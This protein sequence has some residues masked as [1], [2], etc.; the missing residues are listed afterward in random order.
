MHSLPTLPRLSWLER[1]L[2]AFAASLLAIGIAGLAG[3]WLHIDSLVMPWSSE[4]IQVGEALSFLVLG[5]ALITRELG[6]RSAGWLGLAPFALAAVTLLESAFNRDWH[7]S[8]LFLIDRLA[9][10]GAHPGRSA[11]ITGACMGF[12]ALIVI[13]HSAP[14]AARARMFTGAV[15]GS[16]LAAVGFST[17]LGYSADLPAIYDWGSSLAIAP[18]SALGLFLL[19]LSLLLLAWRESLKEKNEP[20]VW[21]PLPAVIACLTLTM[22]LWVGL[23]DREHAYLNAK[24]LQA[25]GTLAGAIDSRIEIEK[26]AF[27]RVART[28]S[29]APE[30]DAVIWDAD[31]RKQLTDSAPFGCKSIAY[32]DDTLRTRWIYPKGGNEWAINFNHLSVGAR[33]DAIKEALDHLSKS[34]PTISGTTAVDG[35]VERGFVIYAP[36]IRHARAAGFVAGEY[37]YAIFFRKIADDF[38]GSYHVTIAIGADPYYDAGPA[39]AA[40]NTGY[41]IDKTYTIE[42]FEGR[43]LQ[44]T[45]T[46]S[47]DLVASGSGSLPEFALAAGISVTA[48]LGLS[49][50][51]FRRARAGQLS[52]EV[53]NK[54]LLSEN[55]ERRR[56]ETRLKIS[57]E[58]L[59]LALDSTEIGIFEWNVPTGHVYYS[60]GLWAMLGYEHDRMPGTL[61]AWQSL[62]H[63]DDLGVYRPKIESQLNGAATFIDLEYRIR[64]RTGDW[65]WIYGRSKSISTDFQGRPARIIGTVQDITARVE[66]EHQLRRAKTEADATSRAKSEFLASMSHEIRTPMNG[67]IGMTS[68]IGETALSAEQRDYVNTIRS[69]SEALLTIINDILD[70]SKIESG[71]MEI[72]RVPFGLALCLEETLDL[73]AVKAVEKNLELGY[74]IARDV[75]PWIMGD[76]TRLW[77]VVTNLV[78]NAVKFTAA[79]SVS[80][81]VQRG[82]AAPGGKFFLEFTVRDTGIGIPPDRLNRLFK[83]F[84]QVDSSTTRK[85][86]GTGLGLA[87]S[88]RLSLLMGGNIRV[89]SVAGSGSAFIFNIL[90]EAA[91]LP[92]DIDYLPPVPEPLRG[93]TVLCIEDHPVTQA[94]LR[95]IFE[96]WD[97][98][99]AMAEDAEAAAILSATLTPALMVVDHGAIDNPVLSEALA[100][101]TCPLLVMVPFGQNLPSVASESRPFATVTKPLKDAAFMHAVTTLFSVIPEEQE[102]TVIRSD[103]H[104]L[105]QEFPLKVLLAED[106]PVN[107]KVA[108]GYLERMGYRADLV[109]NGVQAVSVLESRNYDLI[110]MDLQ[111][112][113]M[114]GLE[115]SRQ[116]RRRFPAERQPKIIALT[117][118]AL[119][120]DRELCIAAGMD[121]YISKPVKLH[122][123]A[124][125]IR[126]LFGKTVKTAAPRRVG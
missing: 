45:L 111:M 52:A 57:D 43:H 58:R 26:N 6:W 124:A 28:W 85:Y 87:I 62:I 29:D 11:T 12:G 13:W 116:I 14:V 10:T 88:Q 94:R 66:T 101:M 8:D 15:I 9:G 99:C 24:T 31:A 108:L 95:A 59:R 53:S 65:R 123:I 61:D 64:T 50:H 36:I 83:A 77:Q 63:P 19:G 69:S 102:A 70:F 68:L 92:V 21:A 84:S 118:N 78:N 25:M 56:V 82:A 51:L 90:T 48:L 72:E 2:F 23:R 106:N 33:K 47:T 32:V 34:G 67:I 91:P 121:D 27:D 71:K 120:G 37:S 81:E 54:R 60:N 126:G 117:A 30:N 1:I 122:E 98:N 40:T 80:V 76:V 41:T 93:S 113:E 125:A 73:F 105:A 96:K 109:V 97:V 7:L 119:E 39:S 55:E 79:G 49:V 107:Q 112:P 42:G 75:P 16:L 35:G 100:K 46:P 104:V 74:S 110:L 22:I 3:W 38:S 115:A 44:L 4:P 20:P 103:S 5:A 114:D 17:L 86:G 89:E 18:L